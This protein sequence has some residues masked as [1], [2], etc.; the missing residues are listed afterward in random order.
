MA[1]SIQILA[2]KSKG[3]SKEF[4]NSETIQDFAQAF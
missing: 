2:H 1:S 4:L 3:F